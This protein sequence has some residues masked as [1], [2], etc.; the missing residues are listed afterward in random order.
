MM[1]QANHRI[2]IIGDSHV[3]NYAEKFSDHLGHSFNVTSYVKLNA[4]LDIIMN[5]AKSESKSMTK[6]EVIILCG[7]MKNIGKN[8]TYK[9]L[10]CI[11]QLETKD[12]QK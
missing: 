11:S 4:D 10:C 2:L 12:I 1:A 7:G 9:G 6:N 3:R 5:T 8:E